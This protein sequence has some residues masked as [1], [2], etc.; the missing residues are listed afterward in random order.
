MTV[1]LVSDPRFAD[2]DM[3]PWHPERPARLNAALAGV[4]DA[5]LGADLVHVAPTPAAMSAITAVH[6]PGLVALLESIDEIGGGAI[7]GDTSMNDASWDAARLAAGAGLTAVENLDAGAA[8]A[9]FCIVRPPG[10]HATP[11]RSM[12]FCLLNN[13]AVAARALADRGERV[14]IVDYDA[15]HGNGT[16]DAFYDDPRVLFV[17]FHQWPLYPGTGALAERGRGDGIGT[18]INVPM[19]AGATGE[20]YRRAWD[21]VVAAPVARFDPTWLIVSAGFDGHQ[22]DPITELGLT[23][24]DVADLTIE[25]LATVPAGRRIV[26]LEGGYDLTALQLCTHAV[27]SALAGETVHPERPSAGG[28]GAEAVTAAAQMH[29]LD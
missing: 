5:H 21:D 23:S 26:F 8:D 13:A 3:G 24:G 22:A 10:H 19:P 6:D 11:V 25:V 29:A 17:S 16:Q 27:T 4:D 14:L 12:G 9:A 2:H 28:P 15:H 18:T 1:L 20:H 7:D